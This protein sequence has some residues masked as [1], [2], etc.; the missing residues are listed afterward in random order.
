MCV[1]MAQ[2]GATSVTGF[3][4]EAR[5]V[6]VARQIAAQEYPEL[7]DRLEYRVQDIADAPEDGFDVIISKDTFE[8]VIDVP[9]VLAS[10][11]RKLSPGGRAYIGFGPLWN[12][13]DG[14]H[15]RTR[16][17]V[18]WLH[19]VLPRR[20]LVARVNRGGGHEG[21]Q[22]SSIHDLGLNGL[23][24]ADYRRAFDH[25]GLEIVQ[26]HV[27]CSDRPISQ[28]FSVIARVPFLTEYFSHNIY[29]ELHRPAQ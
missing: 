26:F 5:L 7:G 9:G 28:V 16:L 20:F 19:A 4:L 18:P 2:A 1:D 3:D 12:A 23:S 6:G 25:C 27:N 21:H 14:D 24:L 8:H 29:A 17:G 15:K 13:P 10:I 22:I 11:G